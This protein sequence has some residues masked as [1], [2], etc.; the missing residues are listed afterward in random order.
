METRTTSTR[1]APRLWTSG[2][3]RPRS[4]PC[5]FCDAVRDARDDEEGHGDVD[6]REKPAVLRVGSALAEEPGGL[7]GNLTHLGD[8]VPEE[9]TEDVEEEVRKGNLPRLDRVGGDDGGTHDASEGGTNVSTEG[10]R[11]HVL[12]GDDTHGRERREGGGCDGGGLHHDGDESADGDVEVAVQADDLLKDAS[13]G[14]LQDDLEHVH[15]AEEARA[16]GDERDDGEESSRAVVSHVPLVEGEATLEEALFAILLDLC[17]HLVA[18]AGGEV[19]RDGAGIFII[20]EEVDGIGAAGGGLVVV[21]PGEATVGGADD[22]A[23]R[24]LLVE[25][26]L[27]HPVGLVVGVDARAVKVAVGL[28]ADLLGDKLH[29]AG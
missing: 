16:Q 25:V 28:D 23:G 18:C 17:A 20:S 13:S 6:Q 3:R 22:V 7:E 26:A 21:E 29:A 5:L 24:A 27:A 14:T 4:P 10:E 8:G 12:E 15:D 19:A 2:R 11:K 1:A 9:S